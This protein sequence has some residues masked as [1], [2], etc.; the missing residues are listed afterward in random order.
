MLCVVVIVNI[1]MYV[2]IYICG[3]EERVYKQPVRGSTLLTKQY[4]VYRSSESTVIVYKAHMHV[5]G[6]IIIVA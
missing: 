1:C 3:S 6:Q 5:I 2:N 4:P